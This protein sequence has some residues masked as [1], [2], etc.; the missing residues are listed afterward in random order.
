MNVVMMFHVRRKEC[1]GKK[2]PSE[3]R[4][5]IPTMMVTVGVTMILFTF[6]TAFGI[7]GM[8]SKMHDAV[9]THQL[10][11]V[12]LQSDNCYYNPFKCLSVCVSNPIR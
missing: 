5:F 4:I 8:T 3:I 12:C 2:V 1:C 10:P 7:F 9:A 11:T 6:L